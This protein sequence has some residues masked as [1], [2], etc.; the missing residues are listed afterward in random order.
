MKKIAL[1]VILAATVLAMASPSFAATSVASLNGTYNFQVFNVK[2]QYGYYCAP[3]Q[4]GNCPWHNLGNGACPKNYN[5]QNIFVQDVSVGTLYFN[6]KGGGE[7]LSFAD[8]QGGSGP[9]LNTVYTYKVSGFTATMVIPAADA[10]GGSSP[11]VTISLGD[12]N[13]AGVAQAVVLLVT[14][15]GSNSALGGVAVLQ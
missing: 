15:T 2:S 14:N 3:G 9:K 1:L 7:F 11:T 10:G 13:S 5:C 8:S 6:G 4:T 12:F